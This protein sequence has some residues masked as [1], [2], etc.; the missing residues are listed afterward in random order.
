MLKGPKLTGGQWQQQYGGR[1]WKGRVDVCQGDG[2]D[3][4]G[5]QGAV[6]KWASG[7]ARESLREAIKPR[8]TGGE[9]GKGVSIFITP[10]LAFTLKPLIAGG[11]I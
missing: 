7:G 6:A 4:G 2:A 1:I 5:G 11:G 9:G 8:P 3:C 10:P